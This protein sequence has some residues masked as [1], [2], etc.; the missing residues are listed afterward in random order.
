MLW[1]ELDA[2][3]REQDALCKGFTRAASAKVK[4]LVSDVTKLLSEA[5]K[6]Q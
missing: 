1:K 5:Q 4:E 3:R 2:A 6:S